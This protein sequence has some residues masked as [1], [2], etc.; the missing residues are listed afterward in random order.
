M[1]NSLIFLVLFYVFIR[2]WLC[3]T[4]VILY[5]IN[6]SQI[7]L[8]ITTLGKHVLKNTYTNTLNIIYQNSKSMQKISNVNQ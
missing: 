7:S 3:I 8:S 4:K 1:S 5:F 6:G 2:L